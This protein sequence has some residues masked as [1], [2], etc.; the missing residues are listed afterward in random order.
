MVFRER[1]H[2]GSQL[3]IDSRIEMLLASFCWFD[4]QRPFGVSLAFK[5]LLIDLTGQ[6]RREWERQF[7]FEVRMPTETQ[8]RFF[9]GR[10]SLGH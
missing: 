5:P 1:F 2:N 3:L 6:K 10:L 7:R 9:S 8:T 4:G